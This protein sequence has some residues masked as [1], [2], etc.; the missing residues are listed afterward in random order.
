MKLDSTIA[1]ADVKNLLKKGRV[2]QAVYIL[3]F[4]RRQ[5]KTRIGELG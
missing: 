5:V 3:K 2:E 1:I 4:P